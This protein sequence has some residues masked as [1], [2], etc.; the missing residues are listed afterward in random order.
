[1][2]VTLPAVV[3]LVS[4]HEA[5]SHPARGVQHLGGLGQ[6]RH[7]AAGPGSEVTRGHTSGSGEAETLPPEALVVGVEGEPAGRGV[8]PECGHVPVRH[9][10]VVRPPHPVPHHLL[11]AVSRVQSQLSLPSTTLMSVLS[12]QLHSS[13]GERSSSTWSN[14]AES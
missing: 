1:M 13:T 14:I 9:P 2:L 11:S 4:V 3:V 12:L 6:R 5:A 8:V 7:G 10:A